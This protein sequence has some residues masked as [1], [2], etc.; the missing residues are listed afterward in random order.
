MYRRLLQINA[1]SKHSVFL[2]GPRG[3]GKTSW[4]REHFKEAIYYDL[5]DD[6]TYTR[7]LAW[8]QRI[9]EDVSLDFQGWIII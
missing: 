1:E 8:P 4:L 9:A 3:T 2:F 7:L 5:L 6:E